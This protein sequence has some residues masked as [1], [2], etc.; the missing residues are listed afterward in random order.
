[1]SFSFPFHPF[2]RKEKATQ[3]TALPRSSLGMRTNPFVA[4]SLPTH[5]HPLEKEG[6]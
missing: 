2:Q 5:P 3:V 4:E 6:G 1:M